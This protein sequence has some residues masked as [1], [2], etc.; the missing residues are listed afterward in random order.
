MSKMTLCFWFGSLVSGRDENS[1]HWRTTSIGWGD[2]NF[3]V[4]LH[5]TFQIQQVAKR[6]FLIKFLSVYSSKKVAT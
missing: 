3:L 1:V 6:L 2:C 5:I 4:K